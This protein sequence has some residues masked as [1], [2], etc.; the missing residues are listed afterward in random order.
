MNI[1]LRIF[2]TF[3]FS[4]V[5]KAT[6]KDQAVYD[7]TKY[8]NADVSFTAT[9]ESFEPFNAHVRFARLTISRIAREDNI[10]L[11]MIICNDNNNFTIK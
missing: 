8:D 7:E 10:T 1:F 4:N 2:D 9:L 5:S 6:S 3:S 11:P